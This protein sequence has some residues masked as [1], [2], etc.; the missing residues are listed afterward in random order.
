MNPVVVFSSKGGNT[1]NVA[2]EIAQE[3]NCEAI[4]L[5][6]E[7]DFSKGQL[8]DYNMVFLGTWVRG[9]HA[10]HEMIKFLEQLNFG[11]SNR[12]FALFMTW[13]G[14][15]K[16]DAWTFMK[17]KDILQAKNQK[18]LPDYY[19]CFG[20]TFGFA[21]KG[22]PNKQELTESRKWAKNLVDQEIE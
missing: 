16:S 2:R 22:H 13:A 19:R 6:E 15:G 7:P 9:G 12:Q 4:K 18:L 8:K 5:S 17:V 3:L 14:G 11:D 20:K 21:R 1:E 10:S